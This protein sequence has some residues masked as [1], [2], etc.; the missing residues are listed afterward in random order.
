[1]GW[2]VNSTHRPLYP[3]ER[4]PVPIVIGG[5]VGAPGQVWA[6]AE[7]LAPPEFDPRT[8]QPVVSLYTDYAIPAQKVI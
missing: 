8:V 4:D 3:R 2:V 5:W 6:G 7:N 1:M